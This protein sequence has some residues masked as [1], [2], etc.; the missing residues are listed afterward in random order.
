[1]SAP[2][3]HDL[4]SGPNPADVYVGVDSAFSGVG[5]VCCDLASGRPWPFADESVDEL[6]SSHFIEHVP[7][8]DV[9]A[10]QYVDNI[11]NGERVRSPSAWLTAYGR[12]DALI[13]V[14]EEA[15][16]VAKPG[17]LFHLSWPSLYDE[18][19]GAFQPWAFA[20]PTHRRFI[21]KQFL[22]YLSAADRASLQVPYDWR[23]NWV[24]LPG[25][26]QILRGGLVREVSIDL[27]KE[28]MP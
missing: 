2:L 14:F 20:D 1:M 7:A 12:R 22:H 4:G 13:W 16:R 24:E 5:F 17:A 11:C 25:G 23:C 3:R 27:R 19:T 10:R 28:P 18:Q 6:R 9:V 21:P 8:S 26:V 15:W